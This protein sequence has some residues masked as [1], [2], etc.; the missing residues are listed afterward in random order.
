MRIV[1]P[2]L[3]AIALVGA[4]P[5]PTPAVNVPTTI[6][7][8][9]YIWPGFPANPPKFVEWELAGRSPRFVDWSRSV[10]TNSVGN[11]VFKPRDQARQVLW[12]A[13]SVI[14]QSTRLT[15]SGFPIGL[16]PEQD[17]SY[18]SLT[19]MGVAGKVFVTSDQNAGGYTMNVSQ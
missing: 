8:G 10:K 5:P 12:L 4:T 16:Y 9:N 6:R 19:I 1:L 17:T 3:A 11:L 14:Q 15:S 7:W 13:D 2:L 18:Q